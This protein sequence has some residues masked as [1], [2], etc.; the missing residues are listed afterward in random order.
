MAVESLPVLKYFHT[1][2]GHRRG[3]KDHSGGSGGSSRAQQ[4]YGGLTSIKLSAKIGDAPAQ[5]Q[6][7][8]ASNHHQGVNLFLLLLDHTPLQ[9]DLVLPI[10]N[11]RQRADLFLLMF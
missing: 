9:D 7:D 8:C 3:K 10:G 5:Y 2:Q 11:C 6:A 1:Q 4:C